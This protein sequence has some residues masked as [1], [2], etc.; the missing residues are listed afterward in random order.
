MDLQVDT[1][2][3]EKHSVS[4]NPEDG[5]SMFPKN[6]GTILQV[7]TAYSPEH[8]YQHYTVILKTYDTK[9]NIVQRNQT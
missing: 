8:Q 6:V 1:T 4:N 5:D 2:V 9:R 7:H 3:S